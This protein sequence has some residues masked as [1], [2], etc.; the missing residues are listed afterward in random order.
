MYTTEN[1]RRVRIILV[2]LLF[3]TG[4]VACADSDNKVSQLSVGETQPTAGAPPQYAS[5]CGACHMAGAAGAPKS[6]DVEAWAARLKVKGMD[7]L[8][9]SVRNGLNAMPPGGLCNSCSDEDHVA[10]ISYMAAAQ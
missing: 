1:Y 10:L 4:L 8:V 6:G 7:G 9:A 2:A 5:S 3:S